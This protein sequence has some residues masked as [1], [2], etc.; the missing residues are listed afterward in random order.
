MQYKHYSEVPDNEWRWPNFTPK[1][2]ACKGSQSIVINEQALDTLQ[3]A[4]T[5]LGA[6]MRINSAYRGIEWNH[7]V[8]GSKNSRHKN[9]SAFDI[10]VGNHNYEELLEALMESGFTGIGLYNTFIHVDTGRPRTW[11]QRE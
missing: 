4:R 7:E 5:L 6:P 9:G 11:D 3:K 8:G 2:I 10:S 1:E